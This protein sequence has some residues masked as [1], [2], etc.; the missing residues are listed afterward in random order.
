MDT[1]TPKEFVVPT[2][3]APPRSL[4]IG[5]RPYRNQ[6][7]FMG[8]TF[9]VAN[10][11]PKL[12]MA[13]PRYVGRLFD[14]DALLGWHTRH[15]TWHACHAQRRRSTRRPRL[16]VLGRKTTTALPTD[17]STERTLKVGVRVAR[18]ASW[19]LL[20]LG[21]RLRI[22]WILLLRVLLLRVLLLRVLLLR[23]L[24]LRLGL[25]AARCTK[26]EHADGQQSERTRE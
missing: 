25:L 11:H 21:R 14:P 23:V 1:K 16:A 7:T 19:R 20:L 2:G 6:R 24:W 3:H 4:E 8:K 17:A 10:G 12:A 15:S 9:Q 5:L 26:H 13:R 18:D 22:P